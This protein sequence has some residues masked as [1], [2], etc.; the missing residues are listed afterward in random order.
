MPIKKDILYPIFVQCCPFACDN[1]WELVFEDLAYGKC[2][3]GTY[4]SKDFLCC[5]YKNKEFSYKIEKKDPEILYNE[6]YTLLSE[7]LGLLS[8]TDKIQKKKAFVELENS[9]KD[10]R[11][12]WADIRKKNIRELMLE[13][14]VIKMKSMHSLTLKQTKHLLSIII[15]A[16]VFKVITSADIHYE[17]CRIQH[18]DGIDFIKKQFVIQRNLYQLNAS[19]APNIVLDKKLMVD[20]WEKYLK[21]LRKISSNGIV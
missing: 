14:Y 15:I 13:L 20:N 10:S 7:K 1:F 8:Q 3:Y 16:M 17:N 9:K 18:I 4:I 2:P 21:D 12:T 6:I 11:K 5:S 19:F